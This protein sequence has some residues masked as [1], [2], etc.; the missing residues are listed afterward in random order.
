MKFNKTPSKA[1]VEYARTSPSRR[2]GNGGEVS[3]PIYHLLV[4]KEFK[5]WCLHNRPPG[6]SMNVTQLPSKANCVNCLT[7]YRYA[8]G[9]KTIFRKAW[10][11]RYE[12]K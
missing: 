4:P 12:P 6:P 1:A 8:T 11:D 5:V 2:T 3:K 9:K 7:N 10:T